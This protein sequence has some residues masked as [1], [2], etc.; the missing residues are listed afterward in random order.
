[1][2]DGMPVL[3]PITR[4]TEELES[5]LLSRITSLRE[6]LVEV[7]TKIK[8]VQKQLKEIEAKATRPIQPVEAPSEVLEEILGVP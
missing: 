6:H 3:H 2:P 8:E 4:G 7:Q 1:M 5:R